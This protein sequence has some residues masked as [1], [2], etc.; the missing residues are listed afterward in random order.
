MMTAA[1]DK[2]ESHISECSEAITIFEFLEGH[3]YNANFGLRF[4]WVAAVSAL[5]HYITEIIVE[6]S[7]EHFSNGSGFSAKLANEGV[8]LASLLRMQNVPAAQATVEFR[9]IISNA[10]RFRTFQKADDISD[11][12]SYIWNEKH[13]WEKIAA[14]LN[15]PA[16]NAKS[17]LNGICS[18][19]DLIVHNADYNEA[20]GDLMPCDSSDAKEVISYVIKTV[21]AIDSLVP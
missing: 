5:D 9:A 7:T 15:L 1:R 14:V 21:T 19:R 20:T 18:R 12:L 8:P 2:F 4:V 16:R 6:K 10:I 3:G 13:K 11:G 17:K